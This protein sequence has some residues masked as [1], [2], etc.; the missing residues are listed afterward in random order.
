MA[1]SGS[2]LW[3]FFK[4]RVS[5]PH[6]QPA[7]LLQLQKD[8]QCGVPEHPTALAYD[9]PL[10]LLAIGT[11]FGLVKI[12][13]APG[14][15]I[16]YHQE[17]DTPIKFLF[18]LRTAGRLLVVY[19]NGLLELLELRT[20]N[21]I[22]E[23]HL[24]KETHS[25]RLEHISCATLVADTAYIGTEKG[26]LLS[27]LIPS[28]EVQD[29]SERLDYAA[30]TQKET[31]VSSE[32][33]AAVEKVEKKTEEV[34]AAA[35]IA[36]AGH[37]LQSN[38]LAVGMAGGR[39]L[40]CDMAARVLLN[41]FH[42]DQDVT[43]LTWMSNG[44]ALYAA[45][46]DGSYLSWDTADNSVR[47][48][49]VIPYGPFPCLPLKKIIV[50]SH[51]A[52]DEPTSWVI[53]EGGLPPRFTQ[54]SSLTISRNDKQD[55]LE[56]PA[57]VV[58]YILLH[59]PGDATSVPHTLLVLLTN[60]LVAVDLTADKFPEMSVPYLFSLHAPLT[61]FRYYS[62]VPGALLKDLA[63]ISSKPSELRP[64]GGFSHKV[65]QREWPIR[66]GRRNADTD[67][68][69]DLLLTAHG[70]GSVRF[71]EVSEGRVRFLHRV[72]PPSRYYYFDQENVDY[73]DD[74]F[75][76]WPPFR[77]YGVNA[78]DMCDQRLRIE[79]LAFDP[80][81]RSLAVAGQ[82]GR[83]MLYT[84][85]AAY[86]V[87]DF[88][89]IGVQLVGEE[90]DYVWR[91]CQPLPHRNGNLEDFAGFQ[92][93][94]NVQLYPPSQITA[95]DLH[96]QWK[97]LAVGTGYGF[98]LI[99]YTN[100]VSVFSQCTLDRGEE[101]GF[102]HSAANGGSLSLQQKARLAGDTLRRSLR[103][104]PRPHLPLRTPTSPLVE[105]GKT[106]KYRQV[107]AEAAVAAS[108]ELLASPVVEEERINA[109]SPS[110][111]KPPT[112][113]IP[114]EDI[115][116]ETAAR[117]SM[118]HVS[119]NGVDVVKT[120][121]VEVVNGIKETHLAETTI[122]VEAGKAVDETEALPAVVVEAEKAKEAQEK[123]RRE[124]IYDYERTTV[125]SVL[126]EEAALDEG[127]LSPPSGN[128]LFVG[129]NNGAVYIYGLNLGATRSV[130]EPSTGAEGP[131]QPAFSAVKL[132]KEIHLRHG[133]PVISMFV[134][135]GWV[136]SSHKD[137]TAHKPSKSKTMPVLSALSQTTGEPASAE[138][139]DVVVVRATEEPLP[140]D[141]ASP[142]STET[143]MTPPPTPTPLSKTAYGRLLVV[144]EEQMKLFQLPTL[145]AICKYKLQHGKFTRA[146]VVQLPGLGHNEK[147]TLEP[148]LEKRLDWFV[149]GVT[150]KGDLEVMSLPGLKRQL[151]VTLCKKEDLGAC[152]N[153]RGQ[154]VYQSGGNQLQ[155]F[156]LT[157]E[158]ETATSGGRGCVV[159]LP[160][161][162]VEEVAEK[163]DESMKAAAEERVGVAVEPGVETVQ[164]RDTPPPPTAEVPAAT[165]VIVESVMVVSPHPA[166]T[167]EP[168]SLLAE[169]D[170][171]LAAGDGSYD[172]TVVTTT[173][174]IVTE[175]TG[176]RLVSSVLEEVQMRLQPVTGQDLSLVGGGDAVVVRGEEE[177]PEKEAEGLEKEKME[178]LTLNDS[179]DVQF[180][181]D[182]N[183][184]DL[185]S[186]SIIDHMANEEP[187]S[188]EELQTTAKK[189][190]Q[191]FA[192][193]STMENGKAETDAEVE[194]T[195][196][197]H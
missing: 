31:L 166:E 174:E 155:V 164:L 165:E 189:L 85:N 56:F 112:P 20:V 84:F 68:S 121:T 10:D 120:E 153:G 180:D 182:V 80:C 8:I 43:G 73:T 114:T 131:G 67:S 60:Q 144:S 134:V 46:G 113:I 71:W 54:H 34:K 169:I 195:V 45:F 15:E 102:L 197:S 127:C 23:L 117:N 115:L 48:K 89:T 58:D 28:L 190:G 53:F 175:E 82:A 21:E 151:R 75:D 105:N 22:S 177:K 125:R 77:K 161:I 136:C 103:R 51:G 143:P 110:E 70:D 139:G 11:A 176:E 148:M 196:V 62:Q 154:G 137:K 7:S 57:P 130:S 135:P 35:V 138:K 83:V 97:L 146:Q 25:S 101:G 126:L 29:D 59:Q 123:E 192:K 79:H 147:D 116:K 65:S 3:N 2:R 129:L 42:H 157:A 179:M 141:V 99:D 14:V 183:T 191:E 50:H 32:G 109:P 173:T 162:R 52:P 38:V 1:S 152:L 188:S 76:V 13:G 140:V 74:N 9:A 26:A 142:V 64:F 108:P 40:V 124:R 100:N 55:V 16:D 149:A 159:D 118:I 81:S 87:V 181:N 24:V 33:G 44:A 92:G 172:V 49:P 186:D 94:L 86:A 41:S 132:L 69:G 12:L 145:K 178:Q 4:S 36:L 88:Q 5:L 171:Q 133:A 78:A 128:C 66:G 37:P 98:A 39:V 27:V 106:G 194:A 90:Y 163:V 158:A 119:S 156:A 6:G 122:T 111:I 160:V 96:P 170:Q 72:S 17:K 91:G 185:S 167:T 168:A 193:V 30:V 93:Q 107:E 63:D 61:A 150:S 184:A 18:F 104:I 95:L 187:A 47:G 19:E